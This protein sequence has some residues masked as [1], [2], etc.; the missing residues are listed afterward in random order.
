M[1][2]TAVIAYSC[3]NGSER[4]LQVQGDNEATDVEN[5][6]FGPSPARARG[7]IQVREDFGRL[8]RLLLR[9]RAK[10]QSFRF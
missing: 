9:G 6:A 7:C 8:W 1:S 4:T 5:H 3:G 10:R 2:G